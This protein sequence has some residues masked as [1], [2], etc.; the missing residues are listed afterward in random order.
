MRESRTSVK[1]KLPK[2]LYPGEIRWCPH[3]GIQFCR[4]LTKLRNE[5]TRTEKDDE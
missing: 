5:L 2:S 4:K 1:R 3:R